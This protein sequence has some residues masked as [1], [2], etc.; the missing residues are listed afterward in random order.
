MP[1]QR[2]LQTLVNS[3]G[4][5]GDTVIRTDARVG[6]SGENVQLGKPPRDILRSIQVLKQKSHFTEE[7]SKFGVELDKGDTLVT[8][9]RYTRSGGNRYRKSSFYYTRRNTRVDGQY[10]SY[11]IMDSRTGFLL[12][13]YSRDRIGSE[14]AGLMKNRTPNGSST[15]KPILNALCFDFGIF[16]PYDKWTDKMAIDRPATWARDLVYRN[17]TPIGVSFYKSAVRGRHYEVSNHGEVLEGCHYIFDQ[18]MLSNNILGVETAYRL[19]QSLFD[20]FGSVRPEAFQLAQFLTRIDDF[21]HVKNDLHLREITGIRVYKELCRIAGVGIDSALSMGKLVQTSDSTYSTALGTLELSLYEQM[22]MFNILYNNDLIES[23]AGHP[24][25]VIDSIVLNDRPISLRD[26]VKLYHPFGDME[27]I[28][29]TLLGLHKRLVS[30][31]SDGLAD[32]DIDN[33]SNLAQPDG[34]LFD[35]QVLPLA[36]PPSNFAKSGTTDDVIR[37]FNEDVTTRRRTNYGIWN[38]V[39]RVDL[40]SLSGDSH[41]DVRDIT[42]ACLGECNTHYTGAR[43]GKSLHKYLTTGLLRR[44][45]VKAAPG[46]FKAYEEYLKRTTPE[47]MKSCGLDADS[48]HAEPLREPTD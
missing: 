31:G 23:P 46:F 21:N 38:A 28:R 44:A 30:N 47:G 2:A 12:A 14:L 25:L 45:G 32:Y 36:G 5:G 8:N 48:A 1:L 17:E 35:A 33:G 26:T 22:H 43:D 19:D 9:V 16:K 24:S 34:M 40:G 10:F 27:N 29:P 18:L 15:A 4:F 13:Y 3:R 20:M 42:I 7:N 37:P 39:I 41:P 11:A 6:S